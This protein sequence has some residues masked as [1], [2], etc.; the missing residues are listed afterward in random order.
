M[1]LE[2]A[3]H[4]EKTTILKPILSPMLSR[5]LPDIES[6]FLYSATIMTQMMELVLGII[7]HVLDIAQAHILALNYLQKNATFKSYNLGNGEGYSVMDVI[8]AAR[9]VTG[10]K[11]PVK[12]CPRRPGDP[13]KIVASSKLSEAEIAWKPKYPKLDSIIESAWQ[14]Q[15]EHPHGYEG[16]QPGR[17]NR[18][19]S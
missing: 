15:K 12:V 6:S 8:E 16:S 14:W 9:R 13:A 7:S 19:G 5:L 17:K 10:A 4:S 1:S 2:Q 18:F 11:I 3:S